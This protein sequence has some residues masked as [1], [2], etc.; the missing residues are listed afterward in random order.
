MGLGALAAAGFPRAA[1][2]APGLAY[3]DAAPF[4]FERL[5]ERA[6]TLANAPSR[7][8]RGPRPRCWNRST[9]TRTARSGSTPTTRSGRDGPGRFPVTFFHLGRYFQKPV[10]MHVVEDGAVAREIIYDAAYF[11]M[12]ADSPAQ[13]AGRRRLCGLPPAGE[14]ATASSPGSKNDWVAFLG[15]SY[16]RAIGEL[17]QYGLSARGIAIDAAVPGRPRNSRTSPTS[18]S[19]RRARAPTP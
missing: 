9:T 17:Y 18:S 8:R 12:P 4:S 14:R 19:S 16:F 6:R 10:H 3:G 5:K 1:L 7:P 11:D 2:A 13:A 15:A